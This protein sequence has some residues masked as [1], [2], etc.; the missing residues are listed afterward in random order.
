MVRKWGSSAEGSSTLSSRTEEESSLVACTATQ[1]KREKI[2][3][4]ES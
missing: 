2:T 4:R 3:N 1:R